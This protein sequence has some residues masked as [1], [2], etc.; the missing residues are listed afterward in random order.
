MKRK[1]FSVII[2][3]LSTGSLMAQR[4]TNAPDNRIIID[5]RDMLAGSITDQAKARDT[6]GTTTTLGANNLSSISSEISN[7]K[8]SH[9]FEVSKSDISSG[10]NW[11]NGVLACRD[12]ANSDGHGLWRIPTLRELQLIWTLNEALK[13][14]TIGF[15]PLTATQYRTATEV[16]AT[17]AY[18]INFNAGYIVSN[19]NKTDNRPVRCV[20]DLTP[21]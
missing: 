19:S 8:V 17:T 16:T 1:L 7:K 15:T 5:C 2:L 11:H 10:A 3:L 14:T 20:R 21:P 4:V 9:Y 6:S 13:R 12:M 18:T